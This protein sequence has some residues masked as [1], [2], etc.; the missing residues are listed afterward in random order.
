MWWE[1]GLVGCWI[2]EQMNER[3]EQQKQIE[4]MDW[5]GRPYPQDD[6]DDEDDL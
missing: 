1:F 2:V 6:E 4:T 5:E 3:R